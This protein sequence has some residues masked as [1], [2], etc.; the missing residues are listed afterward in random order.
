MNETLSRYLNIINVPKWERKKRNELLQSWHKEKSTEMPSYEELKKFEGLCEA[1]GYKFDTYFFMKKIFIPIYHK[2]IFSKRNINALLHIY[3][4]Y[5]ASF[6]SSG[7]ARESLKKEPA[8]LLEFGMEIDPKNKSLLNEKYNRYIGGFE[9]CIHEVPWAVL[10]GSN[11]ATIEETELL[12]KEIAKFKSFCLENDFDI[13]ELKI[14]KYEF[15][16]ITWKAY[17][18]DFVRTTDYE[19]YL[20]NHRLFLPSL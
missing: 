4:N 7:I 17:L 10:F 5:G 13:P 11:S 19:T 6:F 20:S 8:D 12:L 14:Q 3:N 1:E 9:N 18:F 15:Y 2:E 16:F